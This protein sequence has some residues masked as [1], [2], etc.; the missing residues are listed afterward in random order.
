MPFGRGRWID[1][2]NRALQQAMGGWTFGYIAELHTGPSYGV[3]EQTNRTNAFSPAQRPNVAGAPKISGSR[4]RA[5]KINAWFNT[6]AFAQPAQFTF[7]NAGRINGYGP[8]SIAMDLSILKDFRITEQAQLQFRCE[9]LNFIN[10]PSFAL[11]NLVGGITPSDASPV[12]W[13][14]TSLGLSNLECI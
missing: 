14:A 4:S 13:T 6:A 3:T 10:T 11:P 1:L 9:M 7:G 2:P 8:V 5:E 12:C